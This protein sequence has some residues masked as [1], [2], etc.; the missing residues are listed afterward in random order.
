MLVRDIMTTKVITAKPTTVFKDLAQLLLTWGISGVAVVDGDNTLAGVVTRSDL[1]SKLA[2]P[3][4]RPPTSAELAAVASSRKRHWSTAANGLTAGELMTTDVVTCLPAEEMTTAVRRMLD[5]SV[6]RL[7]VVV[8]T[9]LIGIVSRQDILAT[10]VRPDEEVA[11]EVSRLVDNFLWIRQGRLVEHA[12]W[13]GQGHDVEV[14]VADGVVTLRGQ[15]HHHLDQAALAHAVARVR[16]VIAVVN[17]LT[18][19]ENDAEQTCVAH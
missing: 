17:Q 16:G 1:L 12:V 14:T 2:Y 10:F 3:D 18:C 9:K 4:E 13:A 5:H 19:A 8:G 7:P 6:N 11:Q 15:V